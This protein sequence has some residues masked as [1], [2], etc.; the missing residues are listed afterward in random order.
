MEMKNKKIWRKDITGLRA[1]AVL[2]V[3]VFH[4]FPNLL[5]GG[6]YGVDIFFV[7][8]GYL[9]SGII[10]NGLKSETFS[11]SDFYIKRIKR[12]LP[13]LIVVL[14]FVVVV[15]WF[16]MTKSEFIRL[17]GNVSHS[18]FFYQNLTLM[19]SD[20]YFG[21]LAQNNP[22]L[23]IWSLSIEEQFYLFFPLICFLIWRIGKKSVFGLGI[24]IVSLTVVSFIACL[25]ITEQNVRFYLSFTR[26][27]ELGVG[28]CIAYLEQFCRFDTKNYGNGFNDCLSIFGL[29]LILGSV[30][31]P[32]ETY[33]P[34]PGWFSVVPVIGAACLIVANTKSLV[35][36]TLLS[37]SLFTSIGLL[38]YSLYLWHWPILAYARLFFYEIDAWKVSCALLVSFIVSFTVYRYVENPVRRIRGG[39]DKWCVG[40]LIIVL[41]LSHFV[42]KV[43]R[44][45][46]GFPDRTVAT[47]MRF[48]DNW[49]YPNGLVKWS[50]ESEMKVRSLGRIPEIIFIG[51]SHIEQYYSRVKDIADQRHKNIGYMMTPSCMMSTGIKHDGS[52]CTNVLAELE[53]IIESSEVKTIVIGQKWGWYT[54]EVLS[55][56][57]G[58]YQKLIDKFEKKDLSR[59]V[60]IVLDNPWSESENKEF[61]I[62]N[63]FENRFDLMNMIAKNGCKVNLPTD[64]SWLK[65]NKYVQD[66]FRGNVKYI[67]SAKFICPGGICD[68]KNYRDNDH[69]ASEY[70]KQN[71]IW[72]DQVFE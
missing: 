23:H 33:A 64:V 11:F 56:G 58:E 21:V 47:L 41:V 66:E 5:P 29:L 65:G 4:A 67:E 45:Q 25:L 61:D 24:F 44:I 27:W 17:G 15:G 18:A 46:E 3:L 7:I 36:R 26:F 20:D 50:D 60:F 54:Q 28:I 37:W 53:K 62:A 8:S 9:I 49:D 19:K 13:N 16:I 68:L 51:D 72:I 70:V 43:I 55:Q 32:V 30:L 52:T 34:P 63:Y 57:V 38:S 31:M 22:L 39:A 6:F 48:S 69:L 71:A 59:K 14:L 12:I 2:P 40:I 42:G 1:V 10:F 35:N